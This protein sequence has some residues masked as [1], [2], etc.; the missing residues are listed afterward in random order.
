MGGWIPDVKVKFYFFL[1]CALSLIWGRHTG[2]G[3][4]VF[5]SAVDEPVFIKP[6]EAGGN[7]STSVG[8]GG[9]VWGITRKYDSYYSNDGYEAQGQNERILQ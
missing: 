4:G 9:W 3:E 6:Q 7:F 5:R 1:A 8:S 2:W